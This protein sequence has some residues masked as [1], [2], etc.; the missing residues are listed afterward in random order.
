M[1]VTVVNGL[2]AIVT[3]E[4]GMERQRAIWTKVSSIMYH[5]I[6]SQHLAVPFPPSDPLSEPNL[7]QFNCAVPLWVVIAP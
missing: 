2:D 7:L 6:R 3:N 5:L 1:R 4:S